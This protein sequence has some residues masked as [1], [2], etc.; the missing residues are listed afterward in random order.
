M[1]RVQLV[2]LAASAFAVA[3]CDDDE[4]GP[5]G[6]SEVTLSVTTE[7]AAAPG[8]SL[9]ETI[10]VGDDVLVLESVQL[11]LREIEF[12]RS[13]SSID[14]DEVEDDDDCEELE[15]GPILLDVPL[16]TGIGQELTVVVDTGHYDELEFEIHKPED[17]GDDADA[18]FI[19]AH[20]EFE[21]V[22][23]R[24]T[25]TFNGTPFTYETDLNVEQEHELSPPLIAAESGSVNVTLLVDVSTW[26][27]DAA[28]TALVDPATA[29][30]GGVNE[31]LVEDNIEQAIHAFEDD[32]SDGMED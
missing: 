18:A 28:G 17:D 32:D 7:P 21:N 14:C 5:D 9:D 4:T 11:V 13:E 1:R 22:S 23:I 2:L 25:G 20:P 3:A 29:N 6:R 27:L 12:E 8:L 15:V 19:A 31:S 26:F 16:G 30:S 10:T 24:V